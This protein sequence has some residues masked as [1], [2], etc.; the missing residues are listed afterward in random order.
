MR[1]GNVYDEGKGLTRRWESLE[2]L[3]MCR[4]FWVGVIGERFFGRD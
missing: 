2:F 3:R 4:W 1:L